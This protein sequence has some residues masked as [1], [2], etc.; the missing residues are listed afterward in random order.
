MQDAESMS[1]EYEFYADA[2]RRG[3]ISRRVYFSACA[4]AGLSRSEA[5]AAL[6][7]NYQRAGIAHLF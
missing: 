2:E 6:R 5:K 1:D 4:R 3:E 7:E